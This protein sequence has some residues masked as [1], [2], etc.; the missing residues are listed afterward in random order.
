[1]RLVGGAVLALA[2]FVATPG[3]A[4]PVDDIV[5]DHRIVQDP[6]SAP[7]AKEEAQFRLATRL[8]ALRFHQSAYGVFSAIAAEPKHAAF[9][10]TLP[11]LAKLESDLPAPADVDE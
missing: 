10:R 5:E 1:M 6:K 11:W 7:A 8:Y 4:S 2:L 9:E 3:E